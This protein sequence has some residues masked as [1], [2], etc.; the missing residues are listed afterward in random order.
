MAP[1]STVAFG[2]HKV[3]FIRMTR[4]F[5]LALSALCLATAAPAADDPDQPAVPGSIIE[6]EDLTLDSFL[7]VARPIVVF[8]DTPADPRMQQ[9]LDMLRA[10]IDRLADRDVVVLVDADPAAKGPI[11]SRLRP[12][13]F[14]LVLIGK[15][16]GIKLRKPFPY[17]VREI[18]RTIDKMPMRQQEIRDRRALLDEAAE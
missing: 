2:A 9:Q 1:A 12:R 18:T 14:Q 16:G 15:D 4:L 10:E 5:A 6:A 11:R 8:A 3:I 13:G 17:S 7:W